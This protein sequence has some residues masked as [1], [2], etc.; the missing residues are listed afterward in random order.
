MDIEN[1]C[2]LPQM[3]KWQTMGLLPS[4]NYFAKMMNDYVLHGLISIICVDVDE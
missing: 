4:E 3:Q 2:I 1:R